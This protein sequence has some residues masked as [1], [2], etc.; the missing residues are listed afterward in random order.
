MRATVFN[1]QQVVLAE[2]AT[3]KPSK[4]QVLVRVKASALNRIDLAM[5]KGGAHGSAGGT[6][7]PLGVEWAGEVV[8]LGEGVSQWRVGDPVMGAGIGA[9]ADFT[10]GYAPL[11][12]PVPHDMTYEQ[13]AALPVG[14][15]TMHDAIATHGALKAGESIL[16]QGASSGVGLAGLQIAKALGA[17]LVIG[18]STSANRRARLKEFGADVVVDTS[19]S[20]WEAHVLEATQGRGVDLLVDMVAGPYVN[21]GM[22]ATRIGGRMVN[23]GRVAGESGD[24]NF[25]L[26]SMRRITYVGVSFRT[27]SPVE[28]MEIVARTRRDLEPLLNQGELRIPVDKAYRLDEVAKALE[29]MAANQHFGKIVLIHG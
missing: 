10:L 11:M 3:P 28:V 21:P 12:Y 7:V 25:D 17:G 27:R 2:I 23:V 1:G 13:A 29:H 24:F 18:S 4:G 14:L 5:A 16:V 20:G 15:Q 26:H 22:A 9:F 6:G 19:Q 8:E